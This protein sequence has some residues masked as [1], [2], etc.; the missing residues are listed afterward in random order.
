MQNAIGLG[1]EGSA[2]ERRWAM[3]DL[4]LI[5]GGKPQV[6]AGKGVLDEV[7]AAEGR[8]DGDG[9]PHMRVASVSARE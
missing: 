1:D 6:G 4:V 9:F 8:D 7:K 3:P 5:D 2:E